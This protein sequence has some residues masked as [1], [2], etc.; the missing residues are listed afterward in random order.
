MNPLRLGILGCGDFAHR[1]AAI[2]AALPERA[3]LVACCDR[4]EWKARAFADKYAPGEGTVFTAHREMFD[5]AKL[6][7]VLICLPPYGHTDEVQLAAERGLHFLIE[8]PIAPRSDQAWAMVE[9]A[10]RAGV[11]TQVGFMLRF[12]AAIDRFRALQGEGRT[13]A[14]GLLTARYFCNALHAP[15]WRIR[16]KSGGQILEQVIH[17]LDLFRFLGGEPAAVFS[18][19]DNLFH[20]D[21]PG[22]T[23]EDVSATLITFRNGGLGV[24]AAT[25]NA[26]PGKWTHDYRIVAQRLTAD[27]AGPNHA[28]FTP[29]DGSGACPTELASDLDFRREQMLDFLRAIETGGPTRTPIREGARTLDLALAAVRSA[30]ENREI[31]L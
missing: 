14:T 21:V 30:A 2:V 16:E 23:V 3:R 17:L 24:I 7:G 13:G 1:H 8:K 31:K 15:W 28:I 22:Y 29:T 27:F 26:I 18:R 10:E 5:R 4:N 6:D 12:G 25:N 19:Q 20:R 9:A 11:K